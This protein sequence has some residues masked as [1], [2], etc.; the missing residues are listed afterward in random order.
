MKVGP[1]ADTGG[2]EIWASGIERKDGKIFGT[3]D[4]VPKNLSQRIEIPEALILDW[5]YLRSGKIVGGYTTRALLK[6]MPPDE[7]AALSARMEDPDKF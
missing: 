3:I 5:M 2:S 4:N 7:A 1:L 6:R